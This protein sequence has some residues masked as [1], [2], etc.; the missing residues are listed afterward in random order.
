MLEQEKHGMSRENW[1]QHGPDGGWLNSM[2]E[3]VG[4]R[5]LARMN[6]LSVTALAEPDSGGNIQQLLGMLF[7]KWSCTQR[8]P[9]KSG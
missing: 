8:S 6:L 5:R 4:W 2:T 1:Y 9:E 7:T 3:S